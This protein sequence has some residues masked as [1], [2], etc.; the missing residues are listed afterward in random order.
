MIEYKCNKCYKKFG[1]KSDY[2][3]H[4]N[5]KN[6]C[7]SIYPNLDPVDP[8]LD[9]IDPD[10][11]PVDADNCIKC[12]PVT[13]NCNNNLKCNLCGTSFT[14]KSN[15]TRHLKDRCKMK[16]GNINEQNKETS[17]E[18]FKRLL[19]EYE[20]KMTKMMEIKNQEINEL[21]KK[22]NK[23][24]SNKKDQN[25]K[26]SKK[27]INSNNTT[28]NSNNTT[29]TINNINI[30]VVAFKNEDLSHLTDEAYIKILG[31]GFKSVQNLVEYIHFNKNK[32][33]NSNMYI[34]NMQGSKIP[35]KHIIV[36][37]GDN[38]QLRHRDEILRDLIDDK[39][40][41]LSCKFNELE[42]KISEATKRK[43][44]RFIEE[45]DEKDNILNMKNDLQLILYNNRKIPQKHHK[46]AQLES[47]SVIP[48]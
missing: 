11:D 23:L 7:N 47:L 41:M 13:E 24:E 44:E 9:P 42:D 12:D 34:S 2:V 30:K 38:W 5:R 14:I 15:L 26:I 40:E 21:K 43:F 18:I 20:E 35:S 16:N 37:D 6:P 25:K 36:F 1:H 27:N 31:K 17:E 29:N 28:T 10:L 39:T 4:I 45:S 19:A 3:R 48:E 22:V 33:E 8:D 46:V 32:P